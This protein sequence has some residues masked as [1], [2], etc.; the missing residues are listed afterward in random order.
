VDRAIRIH[1]EVSRC[2]VYHVGSNKKILSMNALVAIL[3]L[4]KAGPLHLPPDQSLIQTSISVLRLSYDLARRKAQ[5]HLAIFS[6]RLLQIICDQSPDSTASTVMSELE[7][8]DDASKIWVI[9]IRGQEPPFSLQVILQHVVEDFRYMLQHHHEFAIEIILKAVSAL[10]IESVELQL[11]EPMPEYMEFVYLLAEYKLLKCEYH[12][13][14]ALGK[15]FSAQLSLA[16]QEST[17]GPNSTSARRIQL[18][19]GRAL[20]AT[21]NLLQAAGVFRKCEQPALAE[22]LER[23]EAQKRPFWSFCQKLSINTLQK[24]EVHGLFSFGVNEGGKQNLGIFLKSTQGKFPSSTRDIISFFI[25][26]CDFEGTCQNIQL[27]QD[28]LPASASS[29]VKVNIIPDFSSDKLGLLVASLVSDNESFDDL[30]SM[31]QN[32]GLSGS[33]GRVPVQVPLQLWVCDKQTL[34]WNE[35]PTTG[36]VPDRSY[37]N[38]FSHAVRV[39]RSIVV[40]DGKSELPLVENDNWHSVSVLDLETSEW[41][42]IP[43]PYKRSLM[44]DP[45]GRGAHPASFCFTPLAAAVSVTLNID[46]EESVPSILLLRPGQYVKH[47]RSGEAIPKFSVDILSN[48]DDAAF[49]SGNCWSWKLD[50]PTSDCSGYAASFSGKHVIALGC[51]TLLAIGAFDDP[52]M[53]VNEEGF[54][55]FGDQ[56]FEASQ[57]GLNAFDVLTPEMEWCKADITNSW[58][59]GAAKNP[60]LVHVP[61]NDCCWLVQ[62]CST[63]GR[64]SLHLLHRVSFISLVLDRIS[65]A[66]MNRKKISLLYQLEKAKKFQTYPLKKCAWCT[67]IESPVIR[68]KTC[69]VCKGPVYCSAN[70]QKLHWR[71]AHKLSCKP[72]AQQKVT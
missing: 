25:A 17:N 13:V 21:G 2:D 32:I 48:H 49:A 62:I 4:T 65:K 24:P 68:F 39:G 69:S 6:I 64:L 11:G 37:L 56:A 14:I 5:R 19:I 10:H 38:S 8:L 51:G 35:I 57:I 60:K 36:A 54:K 23:T 31:L 70:C 9:L 27:R 33:S 41:A 61:E 12:A 42:R 29:W 3:N 7:S 67:M 34:Q 28:K 26:T 53:S 72:H 59:L 16:T 18:C 20:Q 40:F 63:T 66:E 46:S 43:H 1:R 30:D 55:I 47:S 50:V 58:T 44:I 45:R 52:I 71:N 22:I 15:T